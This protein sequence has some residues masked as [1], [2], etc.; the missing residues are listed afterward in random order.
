L[1]EDISK[2]GKHFFDNARAKPGE[3]GEAAF[4]DA[5]DRAKGRKK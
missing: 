3:V 1:K 5:L 2:L 4:N